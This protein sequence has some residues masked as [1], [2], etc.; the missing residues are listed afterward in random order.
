MRWKVSK[1]YLKLKISMLCN[2]LRCRHF[3]FPKVRLRFYRLTHQSKKF[4]NFFPS[5]DTLMIHYIQRSFNQRLRVI[6]QSKVFFQNVQEKLGILIHLQDADIS[7][8][9]N[10]IS[11]I[12]AAYLK[13][14]FASANWSTWP[15][16]QLKPLLAP[17]SGM[18]FDEPSL[19]CK[20]R[21]G[22]CNVSITRKKLTTIL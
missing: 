18:E 20:L 2:F 13:M 11:L 15:I 14:H 4:F 21:C 6:Y 22:I 16:F 17:R 1:I 3:K 10:M 8:H 5:M 7:S 9:M 19:I 12:S